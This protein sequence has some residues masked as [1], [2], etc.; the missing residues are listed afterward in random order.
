MIQDSAAK[1]K[2]ITDAKTMDDTEL[3]TERITNPKKNMTV[4]SIRDFFLPIT[5][6]RNPV[7]QA[8]MR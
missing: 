5:S 6:F 4:S 7:K 3:L 2:K 8:E 1:N